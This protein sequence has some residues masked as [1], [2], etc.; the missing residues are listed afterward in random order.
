MRAFAYHRAVAAAGVAALCAGLLPASPAAAATVHEWRT[1]LTEATVQTD[2]IAASGRSILAFAGDT[3]RLSTDFGATWQVVTPALSGASGV[4]HPDYVADGVATFRVWPDRG[5]VVDLGTGASRDVHLSG[6]AADEEILA[7]TDTHVLLADDA[8]QVALSALSADL[9]AATPAVPAWADLPAAP[10]RTRSTTDTWTIDAGYAYHVRAYS[11]R[12]RAT[13]IDPVDLDGSAGP[14]AFRVP[15]ELLFVQPVGADTLEYTY[16]TASSLRRCV[17]DLTTSTTACR[18][19]AATGRNTRV[20]AERMGEV[21]VVTIGARLY[22]A[23]GDARLGRVSLPKRLRV[24]STAHPVGDPVEPLVSLGTTGGGPLYSVTA[25]HTLALRSAALTAPSVPAM[26]GLAA[27]RVVGMDTRPSGKGFTAWQRSV[28]A[29]GIGPEQVLGNGVTDVAASASRVA[30]NGRSGLV[31]YDD[32]EKSDRARSAGTLGSLS[33][34]YPLVATTTATWVGAPLASLKKLPDD[35]SDNFG[36][37]LLSTSADG[38]ALVVTDLVDAGYRR[39][40]PLPDDLPANTVLVSA[41]LWGDRIGAT[42]LTYSVT[43]ESFDVVLTARAGRV[44]ADPAWSD[45]VT[46]ALTDL[47]DGLAVVCDLV[48]DDYSAK[49]WNLVT[50]ELSTLPG[51][52][53]YSYPA[54]DAGRIAYA[55]DTD[56]VVREIAGTGDSAARV[57]GIVAPAGCNAWACDWSLQVDATEPFVRGQ[58]VIRDAAGQVIR[59]LSTPAAPDGSLRDVT[60]DGTLE[61]GSYAP[62]GTYTW[63]LSAATADGSGALRAIDGSEPGGTITVTQQSLGRAKVGAVRISDRTP[64]EGQDLTATATVRPG[65]ADLSYTWFSGATVVATGTGPEAATYRVQPTDAGARLRVVVSV[66]RAGYDPV[67]R[68]SVRTRTVH[69]AA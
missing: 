35:V 57:L 55:T 64:V 33:G 16:R 49:A 37:R 6:A 24:V 61:D 67:T 68:S 40:V 13:D 43:S 45:P 29:S 38:A 58:L 31:L 20:Y 14:D 56:L 50:G 15:G 63:Q 26:L 25:D 3:Y 17:R 2:L 21:L 65:D 12:A 54:V 18:T 52:A 41:R 11:G 51:A 36:T 5:V 4:D 27:N 39:E 28:T 46:G 69:T 62:A 8:G 47:G 59:A 34:P 22:T 66:E 9:V 30:T 48:A 1:P 19:L 53:R 44:A 60:W 7:L 23:T 42:F 32:G 10:K